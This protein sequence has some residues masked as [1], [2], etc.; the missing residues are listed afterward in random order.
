MQQTR[1]DQGT[2]YY[3]KFLEHFPDVNSLASENEEFILKLWQGLGYYTRARNLHNT[4]AIIVNEYQGQFPEE[5]EKLIQLP[6]IGDYTAA[7]ILSIAFKKVYPVVDGNVIRVLS[8]IFGITEPV[9]SAKGKK[10]I[11]EHAGRLI[12]RKDPGTYNQ[13]IMEFGALYCIPRNPDCK[14]CVFSGICFAYKNAQVNNL[15]LKK[16]KKPAKNR[17]FNYIIFENR[18]NDLPEIVI[19]KREGNDIWQNLFEFPLIETNKLLT[20]AEIKETGYLG[21]NLKKSEIKIL[22]NDHKHILS[23]QV[24]HARFFLVSLNSAEDR[25]LISVLKDQRLKLISTGNIKQYPVSQ[26]VEKFLEGWGFYGT[27]E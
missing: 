13:A 12:H 23:H 10:E 7:A 14:S 21:I 24:I 27:G 4:A 2:D 25:Y 9:D 15:P 26:L 20:I 19:K 16:P 8:R 18:G 6:G 3:L 11:Y 17:Y 5:Y 1:I 22:G